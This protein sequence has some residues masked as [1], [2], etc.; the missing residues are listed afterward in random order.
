MDLFIPYSASLAGLVLSRLVSAFLSK[1]ITRN[2][3]TT[4]ETIAL[5][6]LGLVYLAVFLLQCFWIA[7]AFRILFRIVLEKT[8]AEGLFAMGVFVLILVVEQTYSK[9]HRQQILTEI[10]ERKKRMEGGKELSITM[11]S[12]VILFIL[13]I[14]LLGLYLGERFISLPH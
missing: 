8:V 12:V 13:G 3:Q 2:P 5:I 10:E 7:V 14:T 11:K 6:A 4:R 9:S 1:E